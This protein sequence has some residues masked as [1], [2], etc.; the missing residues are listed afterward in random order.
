MV[1]SW[2]AG[3]VKSP[4]PMSWHPREGQRGAGEVERK[5]SRQWHCG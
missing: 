3:L 1:V 2:V 5:R 4:M